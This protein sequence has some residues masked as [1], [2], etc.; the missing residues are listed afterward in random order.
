MLACFECLWE[1][2]E[3]VDLLIVCC[4]FERGIRIFLMDQMLSRRERERNKGEGVMVYKS[5]KS[6]KS[7]SRSHGLVFLFPYLTTSDSFLDTA[8]H[9]L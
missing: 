5:A 7:L 6:Q 3:R 1:G 9:T 2:S 8:I 4:H